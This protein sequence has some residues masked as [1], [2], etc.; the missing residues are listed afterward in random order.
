MT[1]AMKLQPDDGPRSSLGIGPGSDD[2]V[3]SRHKFARRFTEWIG[4]LVAGRSLEEDRKTY[5]KNVGSYRIGESYILIK[6]V[7]IKSCNR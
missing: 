5:H 1:G 7:V 2:A 3:G 6:L 4:K